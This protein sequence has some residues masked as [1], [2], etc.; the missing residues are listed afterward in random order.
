[1]YCSLH[2]ELLT[3]SFDLF[4]ERNETGFDY[5]K[6]L[7]EQEAKQ[8]KSHKI[9]SKISSLVPS[10]GLT[11]NGDNNNNYHPSQGTVHK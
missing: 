4:A 5:F 1:M 8:Q 3:L 6:G 2:T 9:K 11:C 7:V 10:P